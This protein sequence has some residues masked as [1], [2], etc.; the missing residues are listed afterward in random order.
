MG[1]IYKRKFKDKNGKTKEGKTYWIRYQHNGKPVYESAKST[2]WADAANLLKLREGEI[3][4]G[5]PPG[6]RY[7]KIMFKEL[8]QALKEDYKL[9]GQR[10]Y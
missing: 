8:V 10:V 9:K 4:A 5:K 7:D 2:K 1:S 3:A 6:N